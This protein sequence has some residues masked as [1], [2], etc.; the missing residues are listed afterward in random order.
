MF[1]RLGCVVLAA[2]F[3]TLASDC[4][5][6]CKPTKTDDPDIAPAAN[7]VDLLHRHQLTTDDLFRAMHETS[8]FETN[9]CWAGA[10]NPDA[11][12]LS[13]GI[14]QWNL[15]KHSLQPILR[16]YLQHF[17]VASYRRQYIHNLMPNHGEAFF[18]NCLSMAV[19][20]ACKNTIYLHWKDVPAGTPPKLNPDVAK[21]LDRLFNDKLMRQ[22][23]LDL[24][25]KAFTASIDDF[26]N[27]YHNPRPS[28]WQEAWAIDVKTQLG[29]RVLTD[30][31][32]RRISDAVRRDPGAAFD[33]FL[34]LYESQC[35]DLTQHV[36]KTD[37]KNNSELWPRQKERLTSVDKDRLIT[38]AFTKRIID[39]LDVSRVSG[40]IGSGEWRLDAFTRKATIAIGTGY[41]HESL[42]DDL[43][44]S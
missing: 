28:Y 43:P 19:T 14:M 31:A 26:E 11:Q 29:R 12:Y 36:N 8:Q 33:S 39:T 3:V 2:T 40:G 35:L 9:G 17:D 4:R 18:A 23:Q 38:L 41:V 16:T 25:A 1:K 13:V 42:I 24:Y 21:E 20:S 37:C 27:I 44:N 15:G 22:I 7:V 5:A 34:L 6:E 30:N 10:S 32:V